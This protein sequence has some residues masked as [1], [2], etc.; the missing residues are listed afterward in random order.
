MRQ[1][2]AAVSG[3]QFTESMPLFE[4]FLPGVQRQQPQPEVAGRLHPSLDMPKTKYNYGG[5]VH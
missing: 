5:G 2:P 3:Y 4:N 1:A